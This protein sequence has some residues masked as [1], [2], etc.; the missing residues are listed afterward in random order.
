VRF[1]Y[2]IEFAAVTTA[3]FRIGSNWP[4]KS[5]S[6]K[7]R[8]GSKWNF[9]N[10]DNCSFKG[11]SDNKFSAESSCNLKNRDNYK[12]RGTWSY[13]FKIQES[14]TITASSP[15][16]STKPNP[17]GTK[18]KPA[19]CACTKEIQRRLLLRRFTLQLRMRLALLL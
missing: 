1:T 13:K 7:Y 18:S 14:Y 17:S 15:L 12:D 9:G 11:T 5:T 4:T 3:T 8:T 16:Y 2:I 6:F 10:R 19:N